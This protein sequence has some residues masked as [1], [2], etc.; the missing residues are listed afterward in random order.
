VV[1]DERN[2]S[3]IASVLAEPAPGRGSH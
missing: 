2:L 1:A 3:R